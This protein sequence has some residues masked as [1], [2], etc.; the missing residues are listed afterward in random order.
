M[1]TDTEV[2]YL[3]QMS[4]EKVKDIDETTLED[5]QQALADGVA[6]GESIAEI[7]ARIDQLYLD[8]IIPNRSLTIAQTE[9]NAASNRAGLLAAQSSGMNL[10]KIWM[11]TSGH[12]RPAH[13]DADGQEVPLDEP[14]DVGGEELDHP[15][16]PNGSEGNV[17]NCHC[18]LYF[19][20]AATEQEADMSEEDYESEDDTKHIHD[21]EQARAR[22]QRRLSRREEYRQFVGATI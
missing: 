12:P 8:D 4:G 2:R 10:N 7:A 18:V 11:T 14:F 6:A 21:I 5:L 1:V 22:K 16:D 9:V 17:I 20:N 13:A 15:G 19:V 3:L